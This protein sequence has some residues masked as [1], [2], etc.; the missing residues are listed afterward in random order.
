MTSPSYS[1]ACA[2]HLPLKMRA[3]GEGGFI[4]WDGKVG[5]TSKTDALGRWEYLML[6]RNILYQDTHH[7]LGQPGRKTTVLSSFDSRDLVPAGF[8]Y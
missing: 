5:W 8:H 2:E 1:K 4:K 3:R 7:T 6:Q